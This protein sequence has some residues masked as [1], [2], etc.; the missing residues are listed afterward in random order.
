[1]V[2]I[3]K[4]SINFIFVLFAFS[5]VFSSCGGGRLASEN[6]LLKNRVAE[7]ELRI[8]ELTDSPNHLLH[9]V[10]QD[11][12]LLMSIP[13]IENLNL[14][15]EL[16][17]SFSSKYKSNNEI[18]KLN[19]LKFD[20]SKMLSS[21]EYINGKYSKKR[22]SNKGDTKDLTALKIEF[23]VEITE[24]KSG[25]VNVELQVRNMSGSAIANLWLK[26]I[27]TDKNG[28]SYG[29]TQD[30]FFNRLGA[31]ETKKEI[32]SWEYVQ[33]DEIEGILL[34]QIRLSQKRNNRLLLKEECIIG[35]GNVKISLGF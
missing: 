28:E 5:L 11:V 1:M 3:H 29:I 35:E 6:R 25:F 2:T 14:A 21:G 27:T 30:F 10:E 17:D 9:E 12:K 23:S 33:K 18:Y 34:S 8:Y 31:Y 4:K 16:I 32:L 15:L 7:L 19:S 22:Q 13:S 26:A 24:K 20:I